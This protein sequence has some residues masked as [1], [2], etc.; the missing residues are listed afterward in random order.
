ML[1]VNVSINTEGLS[2]RIAAGQCVFWINEA[3]DSTECS[4]PMYSQG[5]FGCRWARA[6]SGC[7]SRGWTRVGFKDCDAILGKKYIS[8]HKQYMACTHK[9]THVC[10]HALSHTG[11]QITMA[12]GYFP[13][14]S[15]VLR[16]IPFHSVSFHST[17]LYFIP[18][19]LVSVH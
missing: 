5:A 15:A 10:T 4:G 6:P 9:H 2:G 8:Y 3:V 13:L 18:K 11:T 7:V 12:Q 1:K 19:I 16:S 14:H 17:Q